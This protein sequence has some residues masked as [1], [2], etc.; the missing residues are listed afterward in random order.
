MI[1]VAIIYSK[2]KLSG[3]LT[4]FWTNS[5]AYHCGFVDLENDT[6]YDMN[7]LPRKVY[8]SAKK[9]KDYTLHHCAL[10][11][12][13][14]EHNLKLDSLNSRYGFL[15]YTLFALRPLFHFFGQSTRNLNGEIC[16]E[17]LNNWLWRK[18][19]QATPFNPLD[20]P[21]SPADFVKFYV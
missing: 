20:E 1:Q 7:R 2:T 6:F 5:Y 17:M 21:P 13:D 9:Y 11:I 10:T 18:R 14:C 15:D 19:A 12:S 16:S 8:W 3:K 4:K